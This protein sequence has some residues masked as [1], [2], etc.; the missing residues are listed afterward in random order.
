MAYCV[1]S[2]ASQPYSKFNWP[3]NSYGLDLKPKIAQ[4]NF[5]GRLKRTEKS[6]KST[7]RQ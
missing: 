1:V 3:N 2:S 5:N 6:T 7:R 4:W